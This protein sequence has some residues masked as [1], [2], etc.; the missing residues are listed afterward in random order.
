MID[1]SEQISPVSRAIVNFLSI[2]LIIF[3]VPAIFVL[4]SEGVLFQPYS[5]QR[6]LDN[7]Q[8]YDRFPALLTKALVEAHALP[9]APGIGQ[10]AVSYLG[11]KDYTQFFTILFPKDWLQPQAETL[12]QNFGDFINFRRND[13]NLTVDL[14][15]VKARLGGEVG[16]QIAGQ[17][18]TSWP[19]CS[20]E[21]AGK[22][23]GLML[24]GQLQGIPICKPPQMAMPVFSQLVNGSLQ[25]IA[26]GVAR[27][28]RFGGSSHQ[29][30]AA[31][32]LERPDRARLV[33][34]FSLVYHPALVVPPCPCIRFGDPALDH[35][36]DHPLDSE[37]A[38]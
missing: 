11:Q 2:L 28:A 7:L 1:N 18:I 13:L 20:L 17:I 35:L 30:P 4:P 9:S 14:R 32:G 31:A 33:D 23:I 25:T 36:A 27:P 37:Y 21:D 6:A 34:S 38:R 5:Y 3:M 19:D 8:F 29:R 12:L 22:V 16:Q 26:Q 24:S 10:Q 15:P